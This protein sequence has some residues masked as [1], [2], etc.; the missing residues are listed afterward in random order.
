MQEK[1]RKAISDGKAPANK[2][3]HTSVP[4]AIALHNVAGISLS[5]GLIRKAHAGAAGDTSDPDTEISVTPE[6]PRTTLDPNTS[7]A[8]FH[9]SPRG[10][11]GGGRV[12]ESAMSSSRSEV[13]EIK[14]EG[15][16]PSSAH[17]LLAQ[18]HHEHQLSHKLECTFLHFQYAGLVSI[19]HQEG[20][21]AC[22]PTKME[23][24]WCPLARS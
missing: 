7:E 17:L 22:N 5:E 18:V 16:V 12:H 6:S 13:G 15:L 10:T 11:Y 20:T 23:L 8:V 9:P 2:D 19:S 14:E 3:P 24:S 4:S 21:R 1:V